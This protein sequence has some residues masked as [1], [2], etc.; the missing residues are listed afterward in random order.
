MKASLTFLFAL[1]F[2]FLMSCNTG[3]SEEQTEDQ[4]EEANDENIAETLEEDVEFLVESYSFSLMLQEYGK[5]VEQSTRIVEPVKE[6]ASNS[7]ALHEN[8]NSQIEEI[9]KGT[10]VV[11]PKTT[12]ENTRDLI[13][14][15]KSGDMEEA[16]DDYIEATEKI[17]EQMI[18]QY[19]DAFGKAKSVQVR[20]FAEL[21][22][23]TLE[24]R[25]K[26]LEELEELTAKL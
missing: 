18:A 13:E 15:L 22:L 14:K 23:P 24:D 17:Y 26:K 20:D 10:Q 7:V 3:T 5:T 25:Q 21:V 4:A 2:P 9:T 11:L 1:I 16:T 8:L 6:F 19:R 12:G